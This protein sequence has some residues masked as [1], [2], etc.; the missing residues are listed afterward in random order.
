MRV[1]RRGSIARH[2]RAIVV[3]V[4]VL[5]FQSAFAQTPSW[6]GTW[7]LDLSRSE[8]IPGPAP[9]VRAT[10]RVEPFGD[11]IRIVEDFVRVRG[12]I[13]HLEWTGKLDG[14]DYR[15]HGVDLFVTYA[16][17]IVDPVTLEGVVKVD[18]AV[19]STSR[20][21]FSADG[22]MV[23]IITRGAGLLN[24]MRFVRVP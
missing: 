18:G 3:L 5:I 7:R 23:T 12:G 11:S 14:R 16:Y 9:Y 21:T 1:T 2:V 24:T 8:F 6:L 15:V 4:L 17:R 19:A 22:G 20:E 10:R 13:T